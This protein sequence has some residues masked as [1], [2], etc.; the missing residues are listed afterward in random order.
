MHACM[1][2]YIYIYIHIEREREI[3]YS[4][5]VNLGIVLVSAAVGKHALGPSAL[6][7][8]GVTRRVA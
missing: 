7:G 3:V 4:A 1:C 8:D 6:P 2:I 5:G